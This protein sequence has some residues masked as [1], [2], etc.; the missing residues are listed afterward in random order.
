MIKQIQFL[1]VITLV[2][3]LSTCS[4]FTNPF[5]SKDEVCMTSYDTE[6]NQALNIAK[7][8]KADGDASSFNPALHR[9]VEKISAKLDT[10]SNKLDDPQTMTE[11]A[12]SKD[13]QSM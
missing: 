5:K 13:K 9:L 8:K 10:L 1:L 2:F 12:S 3:V 4:A 11:I 6:V 7:N